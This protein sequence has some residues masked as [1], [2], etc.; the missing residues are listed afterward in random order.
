M[1][2]KVTQSK[3]E[4]TQRLVKRWIFL[5]KEEETQR[6][7][8]GFLLLEPRRTRAKVRVLR[9]KRKEEDN[10]TASLSCCL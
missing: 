8:V 10:M 3:E 4:K 5:V 1:T 7:S 2:A 6:I 9:A